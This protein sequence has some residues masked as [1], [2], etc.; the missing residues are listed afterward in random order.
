M[1]TLLIG[2]VDFVITSPGGLGKE[3]REEFANSFLSQLSEEIR[4]K[5]EVALNFSLEYAHSGCI[6]GRASIF[7]LFALTAGAVAVGGVVLGNEQAVNIINALPAQ[8]QAIYQCY[9]GG[10][11]WACRVKKLELSLAPAFHYT[12]EGDSIEKIVDEIWRVPKEEREKTIKFLNDQYREI[13]NPATKLVA[14]GYYVA[15]ITEQMRK[16]AI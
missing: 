12:K 1:R 5:T 10:K 11:E 16:P 2:Y 13:I 4:E 8:A 15:L 3:A 7:Q 9:V 6:R 14:P